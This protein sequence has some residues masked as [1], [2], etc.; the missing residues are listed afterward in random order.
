M[1]PVPSGARVWLSVGRTDIRRGM[2]GLALQ[3]RVL[4]LV[5]TGRAWIARRKVINCCRTDCMTEFVLMRVRGIPFM[6]LPLG[7]PNALRSVI[8]STMLLQCGCSELPYFIGLEGSPTFQV[9]SLRS[10][11]PATM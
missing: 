7:F 6:R 1:I 8:V 2:N 3:L 10:S 4:V 9:G 5:Q 11:L